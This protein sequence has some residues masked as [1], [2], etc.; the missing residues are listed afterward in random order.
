MVTP[1]AARSGV[2]R[3][4][5]T[6]RGLV[7]QQDLVRLRSVG[8]FARLDDG[9]LDAVAAD[10]RIVTLEPDEMLVHQGDVGDELYVVL[11]GSLRVVLRAERDRDDDGRAVGG[12]G[13]TGDT[14]DT[15][16][17]GGEPSGGPGREHREE[18]AV[19][20]AGSVVGE[21]A[22]LTGERRAASVEAVEP[23]RLVV[24]P[25]VVFNRLLADH[26]DVA[27]ALVT[28][29][30]DRLRRTQLVAQVMHHFADVD[31]AA[32]QAL[33]P[34]LSWVNLA[35]G[36][37]LFTE[38]EPG[39]IAYL[40]VSGRL[41]VI[42]GTGEDAKVIAEIGRGE[43]VGEM[44]LIDD[45]VRNATVVAVRDSQMVGFPRRAV[46]LLVDHFP[47]VSFHV[48]RTVLRR[49][50]RPIER[51][52]R[53]GG[54]RSVALIASTPGVD[55]RRLGAAISAQLG[56]FGP[57]EHLWSDR[58][59][60]LLG[61]AGLA[62]SRGHEAGDIRL[63][64]W[65]HE[66]E[67]RTAF[68]V[69]EADAEPSPWTRR[70]LR[71]S[72]H[73]IHVADATRSCVPGDLEL[74]TRRLTEGRLSPQTS[75]VLVHPAQATRPAGT[76]A[77]LD[78]RPTDDVF[79][80]RRAG[81]VGGG[82]AE[83]GFAAADVARLARII[84]GRA[85]GVVL[86][87]GGARG[88][89]HLGALRAINELDI[90][91]DMIGGTS[92]GAVIAT[93]E[94]LEVPAADRIAVVRSSFDGVLDYTL[95]IVSLISAKRMTASIV[96]RCEDRH[97]EDLWLPYFCVST[98]LTRCREVIHRRGHLAT[99]VRASVSIPGVMPPVPIDDE[100]LVDGGVLDNLPVEPMRQRNPTGP[101]IAVDVAPPTISS[102]RTDYGLS[103]SGYQVIAD[104][105]RRGRRRAYP[106]LARTMMRS[107][108]LASSRDRDRVV[109][110]SLADLYLDVDASAC[111]PLEFTAVERMEQIG[112]ESTRS[113]LESW[114]TTARRTWRNTECGS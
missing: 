7:H 85:V 100:L 101:L 16:A 67:D 27:T 40:L 3:I 46:E 54:Q 109:E 94:A 14:G 10:L 18:L 113:R 17:S 112:Y 39:D 65:M 99:A 36:E 42:T 52:A 25:L 103:L 59:D 26:P 50:K 61:R 78:H 44:A 41:R 58:V 45:D 9:W 111:G 75:L 66:L 60:D 71:Q 97:I 20:G 51:A 81:T 104:R 1:G 38:G 70:V 23:C 72:D 102:D 83:T 49:A 82:G 68:I 77:W 62:Q 110:S 84:A 69:Y 55:V 80:V 57:V 28:E 31:R 30:A 32:L 22:L 5:L 90:P 2:C 96:A 74:A 92:I 91:V 4:P 108:L 64:Q 33:E 88:F 43:M 89:A 98:S 34:H 56:A 76:S 12:T 13:D 15:G 105:L 79:H 53:T 37:T 48:A 73:I 8:L 21:I 95:P 107:L 106:P 19:L 93:V 6:P 29:A 47:K 11:S 87:G 35:S 24:V 63:V 86:S 114:A